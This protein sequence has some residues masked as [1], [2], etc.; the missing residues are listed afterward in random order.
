MKAKTVKSAGK[1]MA[2]VFW[3]ARGNIYVDYLG[4]R[5]SDKWRALCIIIAPVER[6]NQEKTPSFGKEK[7]YLPSRQC[8][9][10]HLCSFD[11]EN[12]GIKV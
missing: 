5:T 7:D 9:G 8:T 12:Y 1:V 4:K 3:D 11:G 6:R 10:A 2:T